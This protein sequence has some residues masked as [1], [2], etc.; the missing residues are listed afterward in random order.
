MPAILSLKMATEQKL[1]LL[2]PKH[3]FIFPFVL[4]AAYRALIGEY[5]THKKLARI[6]WLVWFYAAVSGVIVYL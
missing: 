6:I 5:P 3:I 2:L 1:K 4:F